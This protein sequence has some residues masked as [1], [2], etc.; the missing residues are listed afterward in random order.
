MLVNIK[1]NN[2]I[3]LMRRAGRILAA[4]LDIVEE[5]ISPGVTTKFLD[6]VAEEFIVSQNAYPA[7]KN[8]RGFPASIC[9]SVN[10][11]VIHGIPGNRKLHDGDIIGVDIGVVIDGYYSDAARTFVVGHTSEEN[12]K[13][14]EVTKQSFYEGIK[15][16]RTGLHLFDI[17]KAIENYVNSFGYSVVRD[18]VGHGVGRHL[19]EAPE[20]PNFAQDRRGLRLVPG[21]TFAIEP[22]VNI[23]TEQVIV[24]ENRWTVVTSDKKC[25]AHYENTILITNGEPEILSMLPNET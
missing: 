15:F 6:S 5:K 18:Y 25:S 10:E 8:Y 21:M 14:I 13:L 7:F 23:G 11:E 17:S 16:A 4:T 24:L 19:H 12:L 22:M 9:T 20:I 3:E 2:E 1:S